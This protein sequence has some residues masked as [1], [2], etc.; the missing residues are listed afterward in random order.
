MLCI[1]SDL[2]SD[3]RNR[4]ERNSVSFNTNIVNSVFVSYDTTTSSTDRSLYDSCQ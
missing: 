2:V 1:P 4:G 3:L